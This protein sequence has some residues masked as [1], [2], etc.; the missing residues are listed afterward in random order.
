[1]CRQDNSGVI[2]KVLVKPNAS[3]NAILGCHDGHLKVAVQ[4]VPE[5]GKANKALLKFLK[6]SF[7]QKGWTYEILTGHGSSKKEILLLGASLEEVE[8]LIKPFIA[9]GE[10]SHASS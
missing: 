2:L 3:R 6:K 10:D 5:K 1:M 8:R 7:H 4:A 9:N